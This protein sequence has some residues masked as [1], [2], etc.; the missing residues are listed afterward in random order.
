MKKLTIIILALFFMPF[1][2]VA[3]DKDMKKLF[4]HYKNK[5]GFEL[6]VEDSDL[7]FDT[8]S[9]FDILNFLDEVEHIYIL[10]YDRKK[11]NQDDLNSFRKKLDKIITKKDFKT[12]MDISGEGQVMILTRKKNDKTS[13]FLLVTK[14]EEEAMF[15][16][17]SSD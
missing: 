10:E 5:P 4:N 8:D 3:Q 2:N 17:A 11:G 15:I 1:Y 16:W 13:D 14:D 7:D 9:D 6:E 12:M